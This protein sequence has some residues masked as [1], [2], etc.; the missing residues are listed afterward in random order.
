VASRDGLHWSKVPFVNDDGY[1]E[2]FVPNG[3]E[4]G[5]EGRNDGG[6][7]TEFTQGPLPIGDELIYYYGASSFGKNHP[8]EIRVTG[9]GVFRAR[10]RRDG[11]VSVDEGLLTTKLLQ[12]DGDELQTNSSG[13]LK[14]EV[15]DTTGAVRGKTTINGNDTRKQIRFS[16]KSLR[17]LVGT[18]KSTGNT[19]PFRLRFEMG[20]EGRLFSFVVS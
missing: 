11:F 10:L 19:N 12:S 15:L 4:G 17:Q 7:I 2:V 1:D 20:S 6:Y 3:P 18:E 8:D 13:G 9:G 16:G 14:L 5:N